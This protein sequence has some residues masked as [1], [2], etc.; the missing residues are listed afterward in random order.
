MAMHYW[1]FMIAITVFCSVIFRE[2]LLTINENSREGKQIEGKKSRRLVETEKI[3]LFPVPEYTENTGDI[4]TILHTISALRPKIDNLMKKITIL[5]D[6]N[7]ML[8]EYMAND[9]TA[10]S[11][12]KKNKRAVEYLSKFF[13]KYASLF[14][15]LS[16]GALVFNIHSEDIKT[17]NIKNKIELLRKDID[18]RIR[19]FFPRNRTR[20]QIIALYPATGSV[21]KKITEDIDR[22]KIQLI[23][24]QSSRII[25]SISPLENEH[26]LHTLKYY[27]DYR[28]TIIDVASLNR[29][30]DRFISEYEITEEGL[31]RYSFL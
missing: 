27:S 26:E 22:L 4:K 29:E 15:E 8:E 30:Y 20:D 10:E 2:I 14:F 1:I 16:F 13:D 9:K 21:L 24:A 6:N 23:A 18:E 12:Y 5:L 28:N 3:I 17:L 25:A 11:I 19:Y 7:A 31:Q